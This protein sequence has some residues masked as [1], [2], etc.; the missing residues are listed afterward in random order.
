MDADAPAMVV[1]AQSYYHPWRAYVD[2][3]ATPL[4]R[5]NYAFQALEVPGGKHQ[6][7]LVYEDQLFIFGCALS[8][9]SLF[10]CVVLWLWW[11]KRPVS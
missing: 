11:S 7:T 5:A 3:H 6:V 1:V 4:W 8:L 2:G 10:A 9:V